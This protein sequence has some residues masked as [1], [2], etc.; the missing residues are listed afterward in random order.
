[1]KSPRH[2]ALDIL[3]RV[4]AKKGHPDD[5]LTDAFKKHRSLTD[6]DRSFVTELVYGTLRWQGKIDWVIARFS[7]VKPERVER[8]ISLIL[9]LGV[10][11]LLYLTKTPHRAAVN[12]SVI[13]AKKL[14]NR[15]AAGFVNALLRRV[16]REGGPAGLLKVEGTP[17][18]VLAVDQSF[19]LWA[20]KKLWDSWGEAETKAFCQASNKIA[21]PTLRVNTLKINHQRLIEVLRGE[22][23]SVSR[24][25]F[26]PDGIALEDAPPISQFPLL[27]S[28]FYQIQDEAAQV[29]TYLVGPKPG[30]R[31]L[32]ACAAPGTKTTHLAQ[33]MGNQ[34]R[35]Y[36]IDIDGNRL[37][38]L[39]DSCR[40]MGVTNVVVL[41]RDLTEPLFGVEG[42]EFDAI[43]VDAPCTGWGTLRRNPDI[44]W[45]AD[46][47]AIGR[48]AFLQRRILDTLSVLLRKGGRMVY[49]TCTIYKEENE[50]VVD[51]F[52]KENRGF[53]LH[54]RKPSILDEALFDN[55]DFL[56]TLPHH[57][58]NMDG[59]FAATLWKQ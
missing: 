10:Y 43:L 34:G 29:I 17:E 39:R 59:F 12:E 31:V 57:H 33:L 28:G 44:K 25:A 37:R 18:E 30:E 36:A 50:N 53:C 41:K 48:M 38:L 11:Q 52:L 13:L 35:I 45:R 8:V 3:I 22:G 1:M 56:R 24:T 16:I 46:Q 27:R 20:I 47:E 51:G 9:R 54:R 6:L 4:E 32:D 2:V 40:R 5:L 23:L 7:Q 42:G 15:E 19:P 58:N 49:S 21:P 26:S 55:R 14:R